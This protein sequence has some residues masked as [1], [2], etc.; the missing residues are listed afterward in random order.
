M[1]HLGRYVT[2]LITREWRARTRPLDINLREAWAAI[3]TEAYHQR[4]VAEW[5]DALDPFPIHVHAL[6]SAVQQA[7]AML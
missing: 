4:P 1:L 2:A 6:Y 3:A 7:H 5:G